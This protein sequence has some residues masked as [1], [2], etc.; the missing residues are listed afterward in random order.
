MAD[1]SASR[2]R[3]RSGPSIQVYCAARIMCL[4]C[5]GH[6]RTIKWP[7]ERHVAS[8][9]IGRLLHSEWRPVGGSGKCD[10]GRPPPAVF[11]WSAAHVT[12]DATVDQVLESVACHAIVDRGVLAG[13][14]REHPGAET[15]LPLLSSRK[16]Q[17]TRAAIVYLAL[18][19]HMHD[20][21]M[22][23]QS[24]HHP[25]DAVVQLAEYC[26]WS[27]WMQAGTDRGNRSLAQAI[28]HIRDGEYPEATAI[29]G[30]LIGEEPS[31]AEA[32]FQ[33]GIALSCSEHAVEAARAF[34]HALRLNPYH[35]GAAAAL[36]HMCVEL[37]NLAGALHYYRL[38]LEIHP[39]L[40]DL[41]VAVR[42]IEAMVGPCPKQD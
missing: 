26:L 23:A 27:I 7:R 33:H 6:L 19:G 8:R 15:L 3:S 41:H 34:R 20:S 37:C 13:L 24:L 25:D 28:D 2:D 1:C 32:Y 42:R 31:F 9:V 18:Y 17:T 36:G 39:R 11:L 10:L 5:W 14:L 21:A 16:P 22:L 35:F 4:T 30:M 40:K 29:L 38:A 12:P